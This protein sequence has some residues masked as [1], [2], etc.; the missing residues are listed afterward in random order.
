MGY[1][2]K[3]YVGVNDSFITYWHFKSNLYDSLAG[4]LKKNM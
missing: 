3:A 1:V 4:S 2:F